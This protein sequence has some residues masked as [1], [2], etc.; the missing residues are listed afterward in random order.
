MESARKK[1]IIPTRVTRSG[2]FK[3]TTENA[4][5]KAKEDMNVEVSSFTINNSPRMQGSKQEEFAI[6][7]EL[8]SSYPLVKDNHVS[9][10]L[11]EENVHT[12]EDYA[13]TFICRGYMLPKGAMRTT[14]YLFYLQKNPE[15]CPKVGTC[16]Y[17]KALRHITKFQ[18]IRSLK[19]EL[20]TDPVVQTISQQRPPDKLWLEYVFGDKLPEHPIFCRTQYE[21]REIIIPGIQDTISTFGKFK[22]K[23][24]GKRKRQGLFARLNKKT[25]Q[26]TPFT[27]KLVNNLE[28]LARRQEKFN[29][30]QKA[31]REDYAKTIGE[32]KQIH[33]NFNMDLSNH[34]SR[35]YNFSIN[36]M[37]NMFNN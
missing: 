15:C 12:L 33:T 29:D 34:R 26:S 37:E 1:R 19:Q 2:G 9:L 36:D 11:L 20:P 22:T 28:I 27:D 10:Q 25:E 31:L 14:D 21:E 24:T 18:M 16:N 6:K 7:R 3:D 5:E 23:G 35:N 17:R 32:L 4:L 8:Q 30:D 13:N